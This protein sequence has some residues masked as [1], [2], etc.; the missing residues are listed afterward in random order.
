MELSEE[1]RLQT[2]NY[3]GKLNH[4]KEILKK[5]ILYTIAII[6]II[7]ILFHSQIFNKKL[8]PEEERTQ[9]EGAKQIILKGLE[10]SEKEKLEDYQSEKNFN[11]CIKK[12]FDEDIEISTSYQKCYENN[13]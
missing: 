11:D 1:E 13:I 6:I 7:F 12:S 9:R 10:Q 2:M 8:N 5:V 3:V 4:R